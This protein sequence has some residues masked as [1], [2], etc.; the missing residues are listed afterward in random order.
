MWVQTLLGSGAP[1]EVLAQFADPRGLLT[2]AESARV[3]EF[4][5]ELDRQAFTAAHVLVR[6]MVARLLDVSPRDV[7]IAQRCPFCSGPHGP[8]R[9]LGAP[10]VAVSWSHTRGQ[11]AAIA[12]PGPLG[13][14]VEMLSDLSV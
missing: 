13:V 7:K 3:R 11:V 6:I 2:S 14:D 8:P 4:Q 12:G 5:H 1:E 10:Q 9:V